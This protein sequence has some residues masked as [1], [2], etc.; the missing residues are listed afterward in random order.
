M[1]KHRYTTEILIFSLL[2]LGLFIPPF[3]TQK[4]TETSQMFKNWTFPF[5]QMGYAF[6]AALILYFYEEKSDEKKI[7][8]FPVILTVGLL[9]CSALF[10]KFVSIIAFKAPEKNGIQLPA[11]ILEWIFCICTFVFAA[12]YEEVLYRFYFTDKL[13]DLLSLKIQ[14]KWLRPACELGGLFV[15]SFAHFYLGWLAVINAAIAHVILRTSYKKNNRI[16]PCV[17]AHFVYNVISLILL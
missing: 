1:K 17:T 14:K 16:W 11:S 9:F 2:F 13:I 3:F 4:V 12:F 8:M 5:V 7:L 15:F 10:I 6:I